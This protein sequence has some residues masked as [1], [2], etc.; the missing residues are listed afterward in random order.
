MIGNDFKYA[1]EPDTYAQSYRKAL[2]YCH[3]SQTVQD[4]YKYEK[5]RYMSNENIHKNHLL[6]YVY[7]GT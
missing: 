4:L 1:M 6:T 5:S 2:Y 3:L 7:S